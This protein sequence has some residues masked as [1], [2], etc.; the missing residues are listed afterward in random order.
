MGLFEFP[1]ICLALIC[2]LFA[3][4]LTRQRLQ[5]S[6]PLL[7]TLPTLLLNLHRIHD[8]SVYALKRTNGTSLLKGP[9]FA[10]MDIMVTVDPANIHYI[11]TSN[12]SNY[13]KGPQF[14]NMFNVLGDGIFNSDGDLWQLHRRTMQSLICNRR[15]V[16]FTVKMTNAKI[17]QGLV[18]LLEHASKH[19]L[20]LDMQ[21]VFQRL[22]F[23]TTCMLVTGHDPRCLSIDFPDVSFS[24]ALDDAEEA[25]AYRH[26][27]PETI[28][29]L[30]RWLGLG[31][32]KKLGQSWKTLDHFIY[33]IISMKRRELSTGMVKNPKENAQGTDLLTSYVGMEEVIKTS[34]VV[35]DNYE[36][37]LRDIVLNLMIAGR[38]TTSSVL[39]WLLW[40]VV[41][42]PEVEEKVREEMRATI[43]VKKVYKWH[44]FQ[45]EETTKL[46]YLHAV[47]CETLRLY[48]PVP[49]QHKS[50]V[51]PNILPSGHRVH[52]KMKIIFPMYAMG[53]MKVVWGEN[54]RKFE[55][56][57]W[58]S[59]QGKIK[60]E[61][62]Y[63][64]LAFNGGPRT[65]L[66]KE[67]AFTQ[68]KM[69]AATLIHNFQF[70]VVIN[71]FFS[72]YQEPNREDSVKGFSNCG[73]TVSSATVQP[74][75]L[76]FSLS[77][78]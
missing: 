58:I 44:V 47:L 72:R 40:L 70:Q 36:K 37:F 6:W 67:V 62:S 25:I 51:Q 1:E 4:Y 31:Q 75:Q 54:C 60:H 10:D 61:P 21:D 71:V 66:G 19:D 13:P 49:F 2:F 5:W 33:K 23:D 27:L 11:M 28:W 46:L 24:R 63:K 78:F 68:V 26:I 56:E 12:F 76:G 48:P 57:R 50:P 8:L 77:A 9:W 14:R 22:T 16:Q 53:R 20:I 18:M 35:N 59:G 30:Q 32:E 15:F 52:P 45:V 65:C 38:D 34:G 39:T 7:G 41:R 69:V 29:K 42:D 73:I 3:C 55:P 74:C 64:F 43:P 17:E